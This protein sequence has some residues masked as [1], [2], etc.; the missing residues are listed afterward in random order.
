MLYISWGGYQ[1]FFENLDSETKRYQNKDFY[2]I[3]LNYYYKGI[4]SINKRRKR[5]IASN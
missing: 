1:I 4:Q 2:N 5:K 3:F